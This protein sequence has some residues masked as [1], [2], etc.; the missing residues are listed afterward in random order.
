MNVHISY[1]ISKTSDLEKLINQQVEKLGRYLQVFRPDLVHLKGR[2][3][4]NSA[5]EGFVV[6][7]NL[8]LPSGQ[9]AAQR[10]C[11]D[12]NRSHQ[13]GV[14]G[15]HRAAEE[16]Q[17]TV[18]QPAQAG[19]AACR[20][21][22]GR[23]GPVRTDHGRDQARAVS[24][25]DISGYI[26]VNLLRWKRF[27]RRELDFRESEEQ[28]PPGQITVDDVVSE[29]MAAALGEQPDKPERMKLEPWMYRLAKQAIEQAQFRIRESG[30]WRRQRT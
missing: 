28:I 22:C 25:S 20:I 21:G 10:A 4:E 19:A 3:E 29:A 23:H 17:R 9:M 16:T 15:N 27:I 18:A 24:A 2:V 1:K 26:D 13:G 14:R 6:S 11:R 8:R 12:G 30:A 7:L 5:R